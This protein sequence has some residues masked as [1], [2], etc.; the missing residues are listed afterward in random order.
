MEL[1]IHDQGT[2]YCNDVRYNLSRMLSVQDLRTTAYRPS[3]NAA[4]ERVHRTINAVFGK[5][6]SK[7]LRDWCEVA[8]FVTF[9]YNASRH[10]SSTVTPFYFMYLQKPRVEIDLLLD[11]EEPAHQEFDE[12]SEK[13]NERM[14]IAFQIV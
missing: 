8:P 1:Q 4:I 5:T 14:Q 6:V 9:A 13:A 12:Y 3:A 11:R 2:E 10:T 7:N